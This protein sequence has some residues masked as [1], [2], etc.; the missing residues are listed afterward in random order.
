V[1]QRYTAD[2]VRKVLI[3][4]L[5]DSLHLSEG[6]LVDSTV[7]DIL[8]PIHYELSYFHQTCQWNRL[9]RSSGR[10]GQEHVH[11]KKFT[12][13][14]KHLIQ[15][16]RTEPRTSPQLSRWAPVP[17]PLAIEPVQSSIKPRGQSTN[18]DRSL[19]ASKWAPPRL[20]LMETNANTNSSAPPIG[21][22]YLTL[23][24]MRD[25]K[26]KAEGFRGK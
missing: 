1:P 24:I 9:A 11:T 6:P 23:G 15:T 18:P 25:V 19:W 7:I 14:K 26:R 4:H 16:T 22:H 8:K 3:A 10:L 12:H 5:K 21:K 17:V 20:I 2:A 13:R